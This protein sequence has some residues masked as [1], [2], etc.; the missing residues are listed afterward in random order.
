MSVEIP[1]KRNC[2]AVV[3]LAA[4]LGAETEGLRLRIQSRHCSLR[5]H[6]SSG[7]IW[8]KSAGLLDV[9]ALAPGLLDPL[10][11]KV[12]VVSEDGLYWS[13]RCRILEEA[14]PLDHIAPRSS[15]RSVV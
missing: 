13:L 4:K 6:S 2:E 11:V 12:D 9:S 7:K 15:N 10:G 1:L 5:R 8:N 3:A 14:R